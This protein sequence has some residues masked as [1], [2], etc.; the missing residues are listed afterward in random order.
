LFACALGL[1]VA[2][3]VCKPPVHQTWGADTAEAT[4][5][6]AAPGPAYAGAPVRQVVGWTRPAHGGDVDC[7]SKAVYY[8]A[9]GES[10][11]GQQAVAQVVLNRARNP[12][13]PSSICAV[14][15]QTV[16]EGECQFSFVCDGAMGRPLEPL[17][18][19]RARLVAERALQGYVMTAV[20]KALNF[21]VSESGHAPG[22]IALLGHHVFYLAQNTGQNT[23]QN[24]GARSA[25]AFA[26]PAAAR[27]SAVIPAVVREPV[28]L[29]ATAPA[30][31]AAAT[32]TAAASASPA[33]DDPAPAAPAAQ[34]QPVAE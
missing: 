4:F 20:G 17:A 8:E 29:A 27:V 13:F 23:V 31:L 14:V 26:R 16:S 9:R 1:S 18:W 25:G 21:H 15:F 11:A 32:A 34:A 24:T 2:A 33:A 22:A 30:P 10:L 28:Q 19:R 7:L 12:G 3:F 6:S 5:A